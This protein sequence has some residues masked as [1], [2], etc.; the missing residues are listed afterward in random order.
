VSEE[1]RVVTV[2]FADVTGS[3][4]I[5]EELDPED[6]RAL[7]ARFYEIAKDVVTAH[8]GTVEK[9]IGDAVMAIFGIPQAHGD[10]PERAIAAALELVGRVRADAALGERLPICCGLNTG[11]V[12]AARRSDAGDFLITGDAVNTAKRIQDAA[13][14]WTVLCGE[15]TCNAA[16]TSVEFGPLV[17]V[18]AKGKREPVRA[19]PAL[20]RFARPVGPRVP[21]LG[22]DA[23]L[24]Q[25]ELA[26]KRVFGERRP[27]LVSLIA[28]AGTGKTR[29]LEEFLGEL[30]DLAANARVAT[31]Q[32]LPYGQ[33]L[34]YWPLRGVL[35]RLIGLAEDAPA[36]TV[37]A[38]IVE[39]LLELGV[40]DAE[41]EA[42]LLAATVGV[43]DAEVSDRVALFAAWRRAIEAA[44]T[45]G[46]LVVV[47]EDLHW[48][49]DSLLDLV[50]HV[51][52]PRGDAPILMLVLTRPELLDRRPGWAGG[53]RN[54]LA[55]SLEP[56]SDDA[57]AGIVAHL[58]ETAPHEIID[59]IVARAEG[60]P[61][62]AGELV[63]SLSERLRGK[64]D[65]Q[66]VEAALAKLPDTVQAAVLARL[67][68]LTDPQRRVLQVGAVFGR[69]FRSAGVDVLAPEIGGSAA[70]CEELVDR[71][72]V[73]PSAADAFVFRHI[74]IREVA[75]QTLARA[76]RG[77][78]HAKAAAWLEER[79]AGREDA[80]AELIAYHYREAAQLAGAVSMD[81]FNPDMRR[82][83]VSWLRRAG[84]AANASA[85]SVEAVRHF[86][87]AIELAERE[88]L[89]ELYL[90]RG[91][92]HLTG[93][94]AVE[95]F[96]T[97]LRLCRELGKPPELELAA[98]AGMLNVQTRS[99][100]SVA[101]R[102]SK[103]EM[104]R[105]FAEGRT[106]AARSTD[107][108]PIALLDLAEGF[109]PFWL[110]G[111]RETATDEQLGR[112]GE[113]AERAFAYAQRTGDA[114]LTSGALDALCSLTMGRGDWRLA[115][116][117]VDR[118]IAMGEGLDLI[119]R[120]DAHSMATW[121]SVTLGDLD[122]AIDRS[123]RGL[124]LLQPGQVPA[125][126][127][128]LVAW[129]IYALMLRG[130]WDQALSVSDRLYQLWLETN[131]DAAGY[132]TRGFIAGL[133]VARARSDERRIELMREAIDQIT[134][135][136]PEDSPQRRLR[137]FGAPDLVALED[138]VLGDMATRHAAGGQEYAE[139]AAAV[140]AD[141]GRGLTRQ[142]WSDYRDYAAQY[143]YAVLEAQLSRAFGLHE[144]DVG[145]LQR[146]LVIF[147]RIGSVPYSARIGAEIA[148]SNGSDPSF[149]AAQRQLER[150]GDE[151]Q[152]AIYERRRSGGR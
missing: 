15:R 19:A 49:S 70:R 11:E 132:A 37:R 118:R 87:N 25:L 35:Y 24:A 124:A 128:H 101:D 114:Q 40:A 143:G 69:S 1:R 82:R 39:W 14:P 126:S 117:I 13:E 83:A 47:F 61:F 138:E 149:A 90:R 75:Y 105:R 133:A 54:H 74:L 119:E 79:A 20:H 148:L 38:R 89:P 73:R 56:L 150:I 55:L 104:E 102:P 45:S 4:A 26:A 60:N 131:R 32:C 7:L 6:M 127:M 146:A 64:R 28:P 139:H 29:L 116:Q 72:L 18:E 108:R 111:T 100:G 113:A 5:G 93:S 22:R 106:L 88:D 140:L 129:R 123:A 141:S 3:T 21:L 66:A 115:L 9:F 46:P 43:G 41:S 10:D 145:E 8:G 109:F 142:K 112:S 59:R 62:Y 97:A 98:L 68:L 134:G 95:S 76:E 44:A 130:D 152:L 120:I 147:E 31:A 27:F 122:V 63:R 48:S 94:G 99:Q 85:A 84:E 81:A 12:V 16:A 96:A 135:A 52:Q 53:R 34:T 144:E 110:F 107:E 23:D 151:T 92:I 2:L 42:T 57:I 121:I 137:A 50:E 86:T 58:M 51:M 17:A 91:Q 136:F 78:L 33:R 67:D 125:W 36:P 77:R 103:S 30:P 71:D 65:L 80:L